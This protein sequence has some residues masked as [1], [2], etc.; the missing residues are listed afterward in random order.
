MGN[1]N[2]YLHLISF[3]HTDF[4]QLISFLHTDMTQVV[5]ILPHVWQGPTQYHGCNARSQGISN[6]DIDLVKPG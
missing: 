5:E 3:L 2:M 4:T 6:H 1:I